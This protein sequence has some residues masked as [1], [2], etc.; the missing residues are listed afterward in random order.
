MQQLPCSGRAD[1]WI[2]R[3]GEVGTSLFRYCLA[4]LLMEVLRDMRWAARHRS[5]D[6][7]VHSLPL[8]TVQKLGR[9][10]GMIEG[11]KEYGF[12]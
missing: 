4:P 9:W 10:R 1:A 8:R 6:A 3:R 2:F 12:C 5:F 11:R 7:A